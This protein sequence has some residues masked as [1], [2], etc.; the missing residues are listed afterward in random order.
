MTKKNPYKEPIASIILLDIESLICASDD[1]V[2]TTDIA[3]D[4]FYYD[5]FLT[6][7]YDNL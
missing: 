1:L 7:Y 2:D 5:I 6:A 3:Y 4:D